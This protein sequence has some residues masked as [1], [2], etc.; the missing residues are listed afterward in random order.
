VSSVRPTSAAA[1]GA[2]LLAALVVG[3]LASEIAFRVTRRLV[4]VPQDPPIYEPREWGWAHRAGVTV[5]AFGCLRRQFEWRT[6]V[7]INS[8][9][10]RGREVPYERTPGVARVLVLGDSVTEAVQLPIE[11]TFPVLAEE[12]LRADGTPVEI[13]N[14]GHAGYGTDSE[15]LFYRHEGA[16]YASD[17]VV[18]AFNFA[19]DLYES[20][21]PL[22]RRSN[23]T[24][25]NR[26]PRKPTFALEADGTLRLDPVVR[27]GE[28]PSWWRWTTN[29]LY[30][31]RLLD[32]TLVAPPRV[33][34]AVRGPIGFE[35]YEA[36]TPE[37][38]AAWRLTTALIAEL[39]GEV[40]RHGSRFAVV[41]I[42]AKEMAEPEWFAGTLA[43]F[44][45]SPAAFDLGRPQRAM[46]EFLRAAGIPHL[47]LGPILL[48]RGGFFAWDVHLNENG[49]AAVVPPVADFVRHELAAR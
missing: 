43:L 5:E 13:L 49:H 4:C 45:L 22:Y 17:L 24:V 42:P 16:R 9:G 26:L 41:L 3:V 21:A 14:G 40:E 32:R 23:E 29:H 7:T 6:T 12:R 36:W 46:L 15:L 18:L 8:R 11:R 38:E 2:L 44:R 28:R 20:S 19:N 39:R 30:A 1:L 37:W 47:D 35:A 48:R 10:L 25:G 34:P 27:S 33:A 31:A